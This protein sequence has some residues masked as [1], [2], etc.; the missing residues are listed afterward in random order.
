MSIAVFSMSKWRRL[1]R[2]PAGWGVAVFLDVGQEW[3]L[4]CSGVGRHCILQFLK[5]FHEYF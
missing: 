3:V 4:Q 1:V 2:F 5:R